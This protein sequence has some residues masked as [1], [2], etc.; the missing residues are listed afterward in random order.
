VKEDAS[1]ERHDER[2]ENESRVFTAKINSHVEPDTMP[3]EVS[4][5]PEDRRELHVFVT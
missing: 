3:K 5:A 1:P 4:A 2:L